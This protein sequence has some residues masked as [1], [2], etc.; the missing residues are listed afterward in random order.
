MAN[1]KDV[2]VKIYATGGEDCNAPV[3]FTMEPDSYKGKNDE[4]L[5]FP[6]SSD[7]YDIHFELYDSTNLDLRFPFAAADAIWVGNICPPDGK[8]PGQGGSSSP[9]IQPFWVGPIKKNDL[10]IY[11]YNVY[12][13][14]LT[15][16]LRFWSK[17][18]KKWVPYDPVIE[19]KGG[20]EPPLHHPYI[21]VTAAIIGISAYGLAR[22]FL[23]R[24]TRSGRN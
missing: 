8:D 6:K 9:D 19:N 20:G 5:Y 11:N 15:F 21:A 24:H 18:C 10:Y 7:N 23:G 17:K 16:V 1:F 13:D 14:E 4:T 22:H 3:K 2:K 12:E